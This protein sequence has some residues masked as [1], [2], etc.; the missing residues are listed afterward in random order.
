M[1]EGCRERNKLIVKSE[2]G[3]MLLGLTV[4]EWDHKPRHV[5]DLETLERG[6]EWMLSFRKEYGPADTLI[7]AQGHLSGT[8]EPQNNKVRNLWYFK[9]VHL[10]SFVIRN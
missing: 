4:G 5:G 1:E 6:P 9:P 8:C 3:G 10:W 2:C 7:L